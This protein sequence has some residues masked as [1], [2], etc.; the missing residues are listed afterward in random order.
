VV[1]PLLRKADKFLLSSF[2]SGNKCIQIFLGH[3]RT[4]WSLICSKR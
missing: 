1:N 2:D 3:Y 4:L